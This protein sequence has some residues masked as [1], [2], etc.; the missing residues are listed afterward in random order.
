MPCAAR[1]RGIVSIL[2]A[3]RRRA[4]P[5]RSS[6]N[7]AIRLY[8]AGPFD[9]PNAHELVTQIRDFFRARLENALQETGV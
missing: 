4:G 7:E 9:D 6:R 3:H 2:K 8:P 5:G 1:P